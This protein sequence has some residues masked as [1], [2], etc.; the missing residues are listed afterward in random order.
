M[1]RYA[2]TAF[3]VACLGTFAIVDAQ[4]MTGV[5]R[6]TTSIQILGGQAN[7]WSAAAVGVNGTSAALD[8]RWAPYC[9]AFGNASAGTT[10]TAQFSANGTNWYTSN[11]AQTLGAAGD[12]G[13]VFTTGARHVRL[14]SSAAATITASI[15]CKAH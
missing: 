6:G 2:I 13:F 14:I 8:T 4:Q 1:V 11:V 12:F 15:Q 9:A 7:A 3:V 10:I 5:P